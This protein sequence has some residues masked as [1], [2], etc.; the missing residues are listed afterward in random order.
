[1]VHIAD[2]AS[3]GQDVGLARSV[4]RVDGDGTSGRG[5]DAGGEVAPVGDG[6]EAFVEE[7]E[8]GTFRL[9]G[10]SEEFEV[11]ILNGDGGAFMLSFGFS[12]PGI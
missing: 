8:F 11:A 12:H 10:Y 2:A 1:M 9:A 7:Y 6:A 3:F 5:S 4:T